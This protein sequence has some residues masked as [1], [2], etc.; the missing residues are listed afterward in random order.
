M[1]YLKN[2]NGDVKVVDEKGV[3]KWLPENIVADDYLMK[4]LK[5][6]VLLAPEDFSKAKGKNVKK[7]ETV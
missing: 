4:R 2:E 6:I 5:L 3:T 1:N 7:D